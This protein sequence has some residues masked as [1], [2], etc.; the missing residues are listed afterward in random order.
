MLGESDFTVFLTLFLLS[1]FSSPFTYSLWFLFLNF[2]EQSWFMIFI[3]VKL[4]LSLCTSPCPSLVDKL[5]VTFIILCYSL[6]SPLPMDRRIH[7]FSTTVFIPQ[8]SWPHVLSVFLSVLTLVWICNTVS[9]LETLSL[10]CS[11]LALNWKQVRGSR[12]LTD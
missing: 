9:V 11:F 10:W 12:S 1:P 5:L 6:S 3:S 4:V 8:L 2:L 7:W